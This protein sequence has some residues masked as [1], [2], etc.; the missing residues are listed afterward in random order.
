MYFDM[1]IQVSF[2]GKVFATCLALVG[3][4]AAM[5]HE[6]GLKVSFL[7]KVSITHLA[8]KTFAITARCI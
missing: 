2:L 1:R 4:F 5:G 3:S 6:V 8:F 7:C